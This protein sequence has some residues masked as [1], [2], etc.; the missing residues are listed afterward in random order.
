VPDGIS[1]ETI[2]EIAEGLLDAARDTA[3]LIAIH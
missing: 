2:A 3:R 1:S